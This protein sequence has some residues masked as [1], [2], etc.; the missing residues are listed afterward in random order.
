MNNEEN[1]VRPPPPMNGPPLIRAQGDPHSS[2]KSNNV[3][4][5]YSKQPKVFPHTTSID[6]QDEN[7]CIEL[8]YSRYEDMHVL[9]RMYTRIRASFYWPSEPHPPAQR[10]PAPGEHHIIIH[11]SIEIKI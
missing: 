5:P 1:N 9:H 8:H 10:P 11:R 4:S 6:I 7:S 3:R 2:A